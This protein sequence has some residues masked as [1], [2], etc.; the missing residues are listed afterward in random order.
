MAT[1]CFDA[2][3]KR[4]VLEWHRTWGSQFRRMTASVE[5][6]TIGGTMTLMVEPEFVS[7]LK[8]KGIPFEIVS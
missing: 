2:S 5:A 6:P 1:I 7:F 3:C 4:D 8:T